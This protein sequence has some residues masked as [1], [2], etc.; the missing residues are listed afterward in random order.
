M[1]VSPTDF[2]GKMSLG[3]K[4]LDAVGPITNNDPTI[5]WAI[6]KSLVLKNY[7]VPTSTPTAF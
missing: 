2:K 4:K 6:L 1:Q 3:V 7:T 5:L